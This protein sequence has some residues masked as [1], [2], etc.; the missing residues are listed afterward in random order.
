MQRVESAAAQRQAAVATRVTELEQSLKAV[1]A[2]SNKLRTAAG[3]EEAR[4][5][6]LERQLDAAHRNALSEVEAER[7]RL[8]ARRGEPASHSVLASRAGIQSLLLRKFALGFNCRL[9][10][11]GA[12]QMRGC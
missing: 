7:R 11:P 2:E 3:S 6:A 9:G 1:R 10:L 12:S 5:Q 8:Q 4:A